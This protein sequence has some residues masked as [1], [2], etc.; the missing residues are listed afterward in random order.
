MY[1]TMIH[2]MWDYDNISQPFAVD[3][4][5]DGKE[6]HAT[7]ETHKDGFTY[8]IDRDPKHF[9]TRT[10]GKLGECPGDLREALHGWHY[11]DQGKPRRE[12]A[13]AL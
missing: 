13:P 7:F 11:V 12:D 3:F 9:S 8:V 5:K 6:V 1:Q 4:M 2:D 10:Y